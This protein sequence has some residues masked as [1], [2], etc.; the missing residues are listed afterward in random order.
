M[1]FLKIRPTLIESYFLLLNISVIL[2]FFSK[3][4]IINI[5]FALL[6]INSFVISKK[7][8]RNI[9]KE[10]FFISALYFFYFL[11]LIVSYFL[12]NNKVDA[13]KSLNK[14][15]YFLIIPIMMFLGP[16]ISNTRI[17]RLLNNYL[18]SIFVYSFIG[19]IN[20]LYLYIMR[21]S[22]KFSYEAYGE[23]LGVHTAYFGA[24]LSFGIAIVIIRIYKSSNRSV[25]LGLYTLLLYFLFIFYLLSTRTALISS[26]IAITLISIYFFNKENL[27]KLSLVILMVILG[28]VFMLSNGFF[29]ERVIDT[30]ENKNMGES[31][32]SSKLIHWKSALESYTNEGNYFLGNTT[33]DTQELLNKY[34]RLNNFFGYKYDY[35]VHNQYLELL[36]SLGVIGFLT[37]LSLLG[38]SLYIAVKYKSILYFSFIII[39]S[40]CFMTESM[41]MTQRGITFFVLLMSILTKG[42]LKQENKTIV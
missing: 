37:F 34:Y 24:F 6:L 21:M 20:V 29:K 15:I 11:L 2:L 39:I 26:I 7:S 12:S 10:Y 28:S 38:Y 36:V 31:D 13:F 23:A 40:I 16:Q 35:N 5:A 19:F 25:I 1:K 22:N 14:S 17:T 33:G 8:F 42:T 3:I 27:Y 18:A 4:N 30:I 9:K 32:I 41:L